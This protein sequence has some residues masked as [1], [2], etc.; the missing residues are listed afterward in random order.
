MSITARWQELVRR[1]HGV[2]TREQV[3]AAGVTT[4][5]LDAQF[6]ARR[7]RRLN[8]HVLALHNGPLTRRAQ[9]WA[10]L[11]SAQRP[12]AL[13]SLT[14]LELFGVRG[15]ATESVQILVRRGARVLPVPGV[16]VE[17]HESRRF[18]S[19]QIMHFAGF[20]VTTLSRSAIDA[21]VWSRDVL[22]GHRVLVAVVQQARLRPRTLIDELDAAGKVRHRKVLRSLLLDLEGGAE[23]LSEV[24]FLAFCRRHGFP[25][26]ELQARLDSGGRRRYL[27][28][29][30]RRP[31]GS[32]FHVEI[33]GGVHLTLATRW[34]DTRKDND[35]ALDR[36][37]VL[38]FPSVAIATDDPDAVRQICRAVSGD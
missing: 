1:Q 22:T 20:D 6:V 9:L 2:A 13:C 34:K 28:A 8:D 19:D 4:A 30:F 16:T 32:V 15:F 12:A 25:R 18:S 33:D 17:V 3:L 10:V 23:A 36:R 11:L 24:A 14:M 31:D 26:P 7:W 37:L 29:K 38:R 21:A 27:D 5:Q 35:A